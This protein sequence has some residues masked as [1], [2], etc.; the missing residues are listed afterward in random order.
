MQLKPL[1]MNLKSYEKILIG[2]HTW[3]DGEISDEIIGF[4]DELLTSTLLGNWLQHLALV[5][6][7]MNNLQKR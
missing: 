2:S 1:L 7:P 4:Y 5:T 3:G 6:Q